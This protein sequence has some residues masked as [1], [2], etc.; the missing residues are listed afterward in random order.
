MYP[1]RA[2]EARACLWPIPYRHSDPNAVQASARQILDLLEVTDTKVQQY[3][4]W[5]KSRV[6]EPRP[7]QVATEK[8]LEWMRTSLE[9]IAATL[10]GI[11]VSRGETP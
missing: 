4:K 2:R 10:T 11:T 9:D 3:A 7:E 6:W 1:A 5:H 8:A